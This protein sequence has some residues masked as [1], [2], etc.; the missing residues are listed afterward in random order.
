MR[1]QPSRREQ[2]T[3]NFMQRWFQSTWRDLDITLVKS[4]Q[5]ASLQ[6]SKVY[7]INDIF[8]NNFIGPVE[9]TFCRQNDRRLPYVNI[10]SGSKVMNVWI[11]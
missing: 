8:D 7:I 10:W 4:S 3:K 9:S 1:K 2:K 6:N 11:C 5:T